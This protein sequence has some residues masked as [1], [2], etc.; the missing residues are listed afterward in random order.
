MLELSS[1]P[2][3]RCGVSGRATLGADRAYDT[4]DF[5]WDRRALGVT[6]HIARNEQGRRSAI[7]RLTTRHSGCRQSQRRR[8]LVEEVFGW[9]KTVGAGGKLRCLGRARNKFWF[10][11]TA[12]YNLTRPANI[13]AAAA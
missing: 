7:D 12:A 1:L 9:I 4:R 2:R 6:P 5:V 11:L 3:T 8:K 13:E 10:E